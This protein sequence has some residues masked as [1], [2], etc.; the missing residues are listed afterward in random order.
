MDEVNKIEEKKMKYL[1]A[2]IGGVGVGK[3]RF[4]KIMTNKEDINPRLPNQYIE[5]YNADHYRLIDTMGIESRCDLPVQYITF[6]KCNFFILLY[7]NSIDITD[8]AER[9]K[10]WI[11]RVK[12]EK[13]QEKEE[14]KDLNPNVITQFFI[15]G[16]NRSKNDSNNIKEKMEEFKKCIGKANFLIHDAGLV[17]MNGK[18]LEDNK[19][20]VHE[21][22]REID[23]I[24]K[25]NL[26]EETIKENERNFNRM[27]NKPGKRQ[28]F[29]FDDEI[30]KTGKKTITE[31][32][33]F[34][35]NLEKEVDLDAENEN[36]FNGTFRKTVNSEGIIKTGRDI[37][38]NK[39]YFSFYHFFKKLFK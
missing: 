11:N 2:I 30:T 26:N 13:E 31:K 14:E 6:R 10:K 21:K 29:Y 17:N 1:I 9:L 33:K 22:F 18:T 28:N 19:K 7:D 5:T 36:D 16:N 39:Y 38:G 25:Q 37:T 35:E 3:T 15:L 20:N 12:E 27:F 4:F 34:N 8:Q 23:N 32:E 24:F